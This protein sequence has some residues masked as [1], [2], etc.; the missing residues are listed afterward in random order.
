MKNE[1]EYSLLM[2]QKPFEMH[3]RDLQKDHGKDVK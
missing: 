2:V 3:A 1:I